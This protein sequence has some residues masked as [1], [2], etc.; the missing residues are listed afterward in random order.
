MKFLDGEKDTFVRTS[1]INGGKTDA[2]ME[3]HDFRDYLLRIKI[4]E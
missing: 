1:K 3:I 2:L 4:T